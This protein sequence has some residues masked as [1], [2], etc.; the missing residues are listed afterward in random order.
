[1]SQVAEVLSDASDIPGQLPEAPAASRP[2]G[3]ARRLRHLNPRKLRD[4]VL[5]VSILRTAYHSARSGGWCVVHRGTKIRLCSGSRIT[6]APGARL[7]LGTRRMGTA[8]CTVYLADGAELSVRGKVEIAR[9]TR[10]LVKEHA[11]FEMG[12]GSFIHHNSTVT[13]LE[14][15]TMGSDCIVS[16]NCNIIDA[17]HHE[18]VVPG[19]QRPRSQPVV[20]GDHVWIGTGV[21]VLPG[22]TIG[23]GAAVAAGSVVVADVPPGTLV[24]GNPARIIHEEVS[25]VR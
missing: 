6:L 2:G 9:G 4:A 18:L 24:G 15:V 5:R 11:R 21:V 1:M 22:V 10:I 19:K 7:L 3:V 16:W 8:P 23:E 12:P 13:C 25:W 17:D 14:R 20:F